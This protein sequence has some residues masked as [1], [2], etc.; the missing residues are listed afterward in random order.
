[1]S[2]GRPIFPLG[3]AIG[4]IVA[5]S[6]APA[7]AQRQPPSP[8]ATAQGKIVLIQGRVDSAT[9]TAEEQWNPARLFQPLFV[10]DRVRT[11]TASRSAILFIDETQVK[12][13]AGA[14]LIVQQIKTTAGTST[15]LNL[16]EGEGWFRTKNPSSGLT[17]KTPRAAAAI[18]GTEIDI[19]VRG[20][21][22]LLTVTE[23]AAE[24]SNDAGAIVVNAGE[25]ATATPGQ[26]P[27]K[28]TLL[29]PEDAVQ[30]VLYYPTRV[31]WHDFPV[32][33]QTGATRDGFDRLIA[34]DR[35]RCDEGVPDDACDRPM[36]AHR[37]GDGAAA[38]G[39]S[40]PGANDSVGDD[41]HRG[42]GN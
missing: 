14:V 17:I 27:T 24:F 4:F 29:N 3:I 19:V 11:L 40:G 7:A 31:A 28:R 8:N 26:L 18:R 21:D 15:T 2:V 20:T 33:A 5:G 12:L 38:A 22:A 10:S 41:F 39:R 37:R 6:T 1:M 25:Q 16:L 36:V 35:G 34:G 42:R 9:A 32:S 30:W 23:G 13:N